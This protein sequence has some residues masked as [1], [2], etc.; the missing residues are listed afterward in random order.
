MIK[1]TF[2]DFFSVTRHWPRSY[3]IPVHGDPALYCLPCRLP[4]GKNLTQSPFSSAVFVWLVCVTPLSGYARLSFP[5]HWP[6]KRSFQTGRA[7]QF[8]NLPRHPWFWPHDSCSGTL[9][10]C[11]GFCDVQPVFSQEFLVCA[12]RILPWHS[13]SVQPIHR[14]FTEYRRGEGVS[15]EWKIRRK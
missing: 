12:S 10:F 8:Q 9:C 3:P 14:H 2:L 1:G 5:V 7:I 6:V 11:S 4:C 13:P 15:R